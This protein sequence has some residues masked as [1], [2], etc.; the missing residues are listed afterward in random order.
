MTLEYIKDMAMSLGAA[1]IW[2]GAVSVLI[3]F[4]LALLK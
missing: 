4:A 2:L 3:Y 1:I